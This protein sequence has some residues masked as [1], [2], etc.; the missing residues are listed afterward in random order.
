MAICHQANDYACLV[1]L[2]IDWDSY[3]ACAEH[4]FD[5]PLWGTPDREHDR[6]E[7]WRER[8]LKRGGVDW[9]ALQADFPLHGDPREL[10]AYRGVPTFVAW[11][12]AHA[13]NW[14]ERF[15]GRDLANFDSH[16]D[17][18]SSSGDPQRVRPGNWAGLALERGLLS[19]YACL[20][21]AWHA[22]V[23]VAEGFDLERTWNEVRGGLAAEHHPLMVLQRGRQLPQPHEVE[24]LLLVQSP[25][26]TSPAHDG[27]FFELAG[28][29]EAVQ[30]S[31]PLKRRF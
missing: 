21:P 31:A 6:L 1:L 24:S 4:V 13:W 25:S 26:W 7:R 20:Y 18:Y 15:P 29:L 23:R 3:S 30:L 11:S 5:S 14:L 27:V 19:S 9:S 17:L 12:H 28:A 16:H 22:G 10:L 8:T 2:S